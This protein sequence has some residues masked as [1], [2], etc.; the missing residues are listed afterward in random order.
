MFSSG[1]ILPFPKK[2]P[3]YKIIFVIFFLNFTKFNC[4]QSFKKK[5][6]EEKKKE[7]KKKEENH[8][9]KVPKLFKILVHSRKIRKGI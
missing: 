9:K 4:N 8:L 6:K 7:E 1:P 5:K 3:L 2:S